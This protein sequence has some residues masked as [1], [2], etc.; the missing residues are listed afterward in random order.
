[1]TSG[2][3]IHPE[4]L[5]DCRACYNALEVERDRL[6]DSLGELAKTSGKLMRSDETDSGTWWAFVRAYDRAIREINFID[7]GKA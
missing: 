7:S 3:T 6:L 1:M 5:S 2:C 4:A